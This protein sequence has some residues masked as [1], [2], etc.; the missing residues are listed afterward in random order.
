MKK[1][2]KSYLIIPALFLLIGNYSFSQTKIHEPYNELLNKAV[3]KKGK[4]DYKLLIEN[5]EKM[6]N[7]LKKLYNVKSLQAWNNDEKLAYWI[8]LYNASTLKLII[9]EYPVENMLNLDKPFKRKFIHMKGDKFALNKIENEIIRPKFQDPRT[10]FALNCGA[11]SCP[12]LRNEAYMPNKLDEQLNDQTKHF[13]RK[14]NK[15]NISKNKLSLSKIFEWYKEDFD[16]G[17][18]EF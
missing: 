7:Y 13:L 14:S 5:K 12:K 1:N 17:V 18:I 6:N 10:H 9:S 2:V 4:V 15:N 8:N 3:N 16:Q 11:V